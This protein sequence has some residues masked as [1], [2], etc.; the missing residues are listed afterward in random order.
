MGDIRNAVLIVIDALRHDRV[1]PSITPFLHRLSRRGVFFRN[2][3]STTNATDPS[4]TSMYTGKYPVRNGLI[5]HGKRVTEEEIRSVSRHTFLQEI[6]RE[7][8]FRTG[9]IDFLGRWHKRGFDDYVT[10][11]KKGKKLVKK[12]LNRL[13]DPVQRAVRS[14]FRRA[15]GVKYAVPYP[16]SMAVAMAEELIREY[17]REGRRFFILI[18]LW[19]T[20]V[21]YA[22]Q[23]S[24]DELIKGSGLYGCG[25]LKDCLSRIRGKWR[26]ILIEMF[27]ADTPAAEVAGRYDASAGVADES[28]KSFMEFMEEEG[29]LSDTLVLITSDHGESLGEHGIWFDHHGLYEP[30]VRTPLIMY[31]GALNHRV[32]EF[33]VQNIDLFP[34]L[35]S[36]LG[37]GGVK[38]VDGVDLSPIISGGGSPGEELLNRPIYVEEAYTERKFGLIHSGF[39]YILA[40]RKEEAVCR[41]CGI[42]HGGL[43]ELYDLRKD[44]GELNNII[45]DNPDIAKEMRK[46]LKAHIKRAAIA[47]SVM[48]AVR[49]IRLRRAGEGR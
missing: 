7:K 9:A 6:L 36:L 10:P 30:T 18:H 27:G 23:H 21:P 1:S 34:T 32:I 31:S 19:D 45:D 39:K 44:P 37:V 22:A 20:H 42:I 47:A 8:G 15:R 12:V 40:P 41:Y 4:F 11:E 24:V 3:Y 33:P 16:S 25:P 38:G 13:P 17:V 5:N 26:D 2:S 43:E 29:L 46:M 49:S 48:R 35:S 28:V 14:L